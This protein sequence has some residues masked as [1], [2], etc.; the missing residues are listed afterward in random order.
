MHVAREAWWLLGPLLICGFILAL[1]LDSAWPWMIASLIVLT[2][3]SGF[4]DSDRQVPP[5]P[6]G[7]VAPLDG[8]IVRRRECHDP[9]LDRAAIRLTIKLNR[10]GVYYFRAPT[11]GMLM[12]L[13]VGKKIRHSEQASWIRTDEKDDIVMVVSAGSLLGERPCSAGFGQRVGQ[14]RRCGPRR[15]ARQLDVYIPANCRVDVTLGEKVRAG[16]DVL[17][18]MVHNVPKIYVV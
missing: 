2:I 9:Y 7:L 15:L 3:A 10:Y 18:T 13:R 1:S 17:A 4:R 8:I 16:S 5:H 11:E 12:E 14:G 6:L